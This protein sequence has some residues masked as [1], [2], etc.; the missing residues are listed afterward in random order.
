LQYI[1]FPTDY[2]S[3]KKKNKERSLTKAEAREWNDK[4]QTAWRYSVTHR[5]SSNPLNL[6]LQSSSAFQT[7]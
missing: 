3:K 2:G 1:L 6:T 5:L 4:V 7:N